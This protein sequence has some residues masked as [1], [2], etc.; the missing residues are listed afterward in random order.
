MVNAKF[1]LQIFCCS[2]FFFVSLGPG[3]L[4]RSYLTILSRVCELTRL[5]PNT[6]IPGP[7]VEQVFSRLSSSCPQYTNSLHTLTG[8]RPK[9][10]KPSGIPEKSPKSILATSQTALSILQSSSYTSTKD[11]SPRLRTASDV[12]L[13]SDS[14]PSP[15]PDMSL[16]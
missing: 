8:T 14:P 11:R 9:E 12:M 10:I 16:T 7:C 3:I 13:P 2:I 5:F 15:P 1:S 6:G 4:W